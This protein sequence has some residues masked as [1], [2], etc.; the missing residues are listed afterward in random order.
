MPQ[1][2]LHNSQPGIANPRISTTFTNAFENLDPRNPSPNLQSLVS[3]NQSRLGVYLH[4]TIPRAY[5]AGRSQASQPG[6]PPLNPTFPLV[7]NRWLLVRILRT[8]T[9]ASASPDRAAAWV[10][11]S[12]RLSKI[13]DLDVSVDL[14]TDITPFVA[15]SNDADT[16]SDILNNQAENYIGL[17]TPLATWK[18]NTTAQRV[19]LTVMNTSNPLFADY[20][21]HNPNVFS[22][23]DNFMYGTDKNGNP[24]YL[25]SATCDY[26]IV[27]WHSAQGDDP[28]G[29]IADPAAPETLQ[30]RLNDLFCAAPTLTNSNDT[31]TTASNLSTG[32]GRLICHAAR[33][34]VAY[35]SLVKPPTP[36]DT[37]AAYFGPDVDMEPTALGTSPLDA[38]M[39]FL[40]AHSQDQAFEESTLQFLD[41]TIVQTLMGIRELLYVSEDDYDSRVQAADLVFSHNFGRSPGGFTWHYNKQK[42][43]NSPPQAPSTVKDSNGKSEVDYLNDLNELQQTWDATSRKLSLLGWALFS[44]F[45][46]YV[47]D[48]T[49]DSAQNRKLLYSSRIP[50]LRTE[51]TNLSQMQKDIDSKIAQTAA[52][53]PSKKVANDAFFKRKDPTLLLAGLDSGWDAEFLSNTPTRYSHQ[54]SAAGSGDTSLVGA[55]RTLISKLGLAAD[56]TATVDKLVV[57]ASGGYQSQLSQYGHKQWSQQPFS[58]QFVEWEGI[59]YHVDDF[60]SQWKVN[61]TES[62][63]SASNHSQVRYINPNQL[64]TLT[65]PNPREDQ[66]HISGRMLILPQPS[67][68]LGAVVGSV[69]AGTPLAELP[70]ALQ[71][72]DQQTQFIQNV[73]SLKF[74]SGELTGLTDALVTMAAGQHVKPNVRPNGAA[75]HPMKAAVDVGSNIGLQSGDFDLIG[76]DTGQTPYGTLTDFTNVNAN[77][78]KSVQHGQFGEGHHFKSENVC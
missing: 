36:A 21:I 77:P 50:L 59:Y 12:D 55:T 46:K 64:S 42:D 15:Y 71:T 14:E 29:V 24:L 33:Y 73:Q 35:N 2:D 74:I 48:G 68:A 7:P 65:S 66:R 22:T 39:T 3:I 45:F 53:V 5:R 54:T 49:S 43:P 69:V 18:E 38:V 11:E 9:P 26:I 32:T 58:P 51:A 25:N 19:Q 67:F 17:K 4:W 57:E 76:A 40:Q 20:A 28:L 52:K 78:F 31:T 61:L 34:G 37:Y 30:A 23:K 62:A 27:G 10:I 70:S 8:W 56:L 13:E 63:I 72:K 60:P 75:P 47:S 1:I 41:P 16:N 6:D 44:E